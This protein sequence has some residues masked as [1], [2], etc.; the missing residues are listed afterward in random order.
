MLTRRSARSIEVE[1]RDPVDARTLAEAARIVD[2]VRDG[3]EAALL[4]W[5]E[6]FGDLD[7]E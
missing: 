2:A 5:A 6:R 7:G 4:T 3:G 1:R